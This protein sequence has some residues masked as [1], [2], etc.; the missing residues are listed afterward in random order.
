MV[1][2]KAKVC[3][4]CWY[5][6]RTDPTNPKP[7]YGLQNGFVI[8][9]SVFL[10]IFVLATLAVITSQNKPEAATSLPEIAGKG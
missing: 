1:H 7:K 8:V 6:F 5:D 4:Y 2:V 9:A 3:C 10:L